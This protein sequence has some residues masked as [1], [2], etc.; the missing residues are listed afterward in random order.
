MTVLDNGWL[1]AAAIKKAKMGFY[2]RPPTIEEGGR[3]HRRSI[4]GL[5]QP[6]DDAKARGHAAISQLVAD[7]YIDSVMASRG[8][9]LIEVI[10]KTNTV[11][12]SIA[13]EDGGLIF[14]WA[15]RNMAITIQIFPS[16]GYWWSVRNIAEVSYADGG[17]DLPL[18]DLRHS[19]N[20]F[21]KEVER[22]NPNWRSIVR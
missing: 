10:F 9:Q 22:Q 2:F 21:S 17:S 1:K 15:A 5:L 11:D 3:M 18:Q 13:P 8:R 20:Q 14:Y 7:E 12:A 4:G 19:V 16:A 6:V